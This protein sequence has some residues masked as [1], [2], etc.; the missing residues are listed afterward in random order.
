MKG[1]RLVFG[2]IYESVEVIDYLLCLSFVVF[3]K[4]IDEISDFFMGIGLDD[5]IEEFF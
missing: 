1:Y 2:V 4:S 5:F 3:V